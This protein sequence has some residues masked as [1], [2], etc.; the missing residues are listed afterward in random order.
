MLMEKDLRNTQLIECCIVRTARKPWRCI[1]ADEFRSFDAVRVCDHGDWKATSSSRHL[2]REAAETAL[3]EARARAG[4]GRPCHGEHV[5]LDAAFYV[6]A[7]PNPEYR[8][9]C[10]VDIAVGDTYVEYVGE[11]PAFW[12]SGDRYCA[13]CAQTW[14]VNTA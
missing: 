8:P 12:Q 6:A 9:D 14:V 7:N 1:G 11:T 13:R 5:A 3:A 2:T 10:L 4:A